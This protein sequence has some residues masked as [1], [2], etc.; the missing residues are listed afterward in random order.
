MD[1]AG[2]FETH[3]TVRPPAGTDRSLAGW[4]AA[5]GLKY[6]R[7][8]LDRGA[9][10]DQPMLTARGRGTL[11]ELRAAAAG[12]A[13]RLRAAGFP[14]TRIKVEATPWNTGV[15]QTP[16]DATTE[17]PDR[18]FEH[19]V[20]VVLTTDRLPA[21]RDLAIPHNAHVSHNARRTLAPGGPV[22]PVSPGGRVTPGGP[23]TPG[24]A[25]GPD[26][27]GPQRHERFVT[28]RCHRVGRPAAKAALDEL[29]AALAAADFPVIEVEEE[30]VACD[31]NLALDTGWLTTDRP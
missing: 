10:P 24:G 20:K 6:S 13:D 31:D 5:H 4:A 11:A 23:V 9:T 21:L 27:P 1:L 12:W 18:Y 14:V 8:V 28:Q 16:E 30:Y 3:L 15:P 26:G 2:E 17:P 7:I 25:A 22:T 19:H 29:L